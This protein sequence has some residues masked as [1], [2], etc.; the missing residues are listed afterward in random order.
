MKKIYFVSFLIFALS[1]KTLREGCPKKK[2][3][4]DNTCI[5]K[6][7]EGYITTYQNDYAECQKC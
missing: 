1:K 3:M 2:V 5:R 6:C 7:P 4:F